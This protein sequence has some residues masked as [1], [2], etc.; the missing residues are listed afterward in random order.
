MDESLADFTVEMVNCEET[1]LAEIAEPVCKRRDVAQT[2]RLA[3]ESSERDR[4]D[5]KRVNE[6]IIARWSRSALEYI[7][8]QAHSGKCF[9]VKGGS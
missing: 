2:Y 1:L 6:A 7:K 4:I 9:S 5:W 8:Q 3:M